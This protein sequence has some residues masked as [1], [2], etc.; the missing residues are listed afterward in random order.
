MAEGFKDLQRVSQLR[1][2]LGWEYGTATLFG[3]N[4]ASIYMTERP[5][6]HS[7]VKHIENKFHKAG[8]LVEKKPLR[9]QHVGTNDMVADVMTK[10]L[11]RGRV[12]SERFRSMLKVLPLKDVLEH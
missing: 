8:D 10:G 11:G 9:V 2:E 4:M 3:D 6:K 1:D 12:K 5:G 7:R